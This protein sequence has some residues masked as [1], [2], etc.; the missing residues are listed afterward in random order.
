MESESVVDGQSPPESVK[1]EIF[2]VQ[3]GNLN[4]I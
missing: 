4:Y 2:F 1:R 3:K